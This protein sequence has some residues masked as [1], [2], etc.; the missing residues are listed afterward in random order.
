VCRQRAV[1]DERTAV[2]EQA[3]RG[4]ENRGEEAE[5]VQPDLPAGRN[6]RQ[7]GPVL[8]ARVGGNARLIADAFELYVAKGTKVADIT[9]G[10][11]VWWKELDERDYLLEK[12][13]LHP[14]KADDYDVVEA[15][16]RWLDCCESRYFD[17]VLFDPPYMHGGQTVKQS[18][19]KC[20]LNENES[21]ES[22]IRLYG[23][24][25]LSAARIL[26]IG[27]KV[28]VKCQDEIESNRQRLTHCEVIQLLELFGFRI[29]DILVLVQETVP[30]M[31]YDFQKTA[32]KNHSYLVVGELRR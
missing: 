21:H 20:Y 6:G 32:R 24:G 15:D 23:A 7:A 12:F 4:V 25:L 31:R 9:Y 14:V 28:L 1:G 13:D 11:G 27:G 30:A 19:N 8:T 18:I 26:V 17:A 29:V 2:A 16:F 3:V 5:P 22:I 10:R